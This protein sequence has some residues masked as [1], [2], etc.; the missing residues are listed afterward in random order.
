MKTNIMRCRSSWTRDRLNG[1]PP[2]QA[3]RIVLVDWNRMEHA[4]DEDR[5]ARGFPDFLA[6]KS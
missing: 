5:I 3:R 2:N 6:E 4:V 1:V